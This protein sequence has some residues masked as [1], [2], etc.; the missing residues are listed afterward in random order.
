MRLRVYF[1]RRGLCPGVA[2]GRCRGQLVAGQG[3]EEPSDT[4]EDAEDGLDEVGG[5]LRP[6]VHVED[7]EHGHQADQD[8]GDPLLHG[9][10]L[11]MNSRHPGLG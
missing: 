1:N 9:F 5:C 6:G 7:R 10:H 8:V 2:E 11:Q 4:V 3:F